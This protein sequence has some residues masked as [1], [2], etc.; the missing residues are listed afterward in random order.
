M[1]KVYFPNLNGL[2]FIAAFLVIIHH[3]EQFKSMFGLP[4]NWKNPF[5]SIVGPLGV[6]LFF[7]LS[8][9]L[10]T[11]LLM[12]EERKTGTIAIRKFYIRRILRIWPLYYLIVLAG[13]FLLNHLSLL[14][15]GDLSRAVWVDGWPKLLLFVLFLPNIAYAFFLPVPFVSQSWSVGVEEQFYLIWPWLMKK[16]KNKKRALFGVLAV[17]LLVKFLLQ[18][19]HKFASN[20]NVELVY[21][22]WGNFSIDCMAIGGIYALLLFRNAPALKI[23]FNRGV[24]FGTY[25]LLVLLLITG[26]VVP[27][28]HFEVYALLFGIVIINLA[29][30][31][32]RLFSL[33][34][35]WLNYLGT[36]SYGLYMYHAIAIVAG[37]RLLSSAGIHSG[38][39]QYA[40]SILFAIIISSVS[41]EFF[42][43]KYIRMKARFSEVISGENA[44]KA[45]ENT[46]KPLS[47]QSHESNTI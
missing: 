7:V 15:V 29:A 24:Q 20:S 27:H 3:L 44:S 46:L 36:I 12:A 1:D 21:G 18:L 26:T 14:N 10:I 32:R 16:T 40:V 19:A 11:Y 22:I 38:V 8:G 5:V 28:V 13:F 23:L 17:Y 41:Y 4:N 43:K 35:P 45:P 2:R 39:I 33:D 42:E 30:N 9:F 25:L 31:P 34:T 47:T 37:L 6:V